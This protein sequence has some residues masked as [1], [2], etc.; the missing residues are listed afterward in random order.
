MEKETA[1]GVNLA[2]LSAVIKNWNSLND[3]TRAEIVRLILENL[4]R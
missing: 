2:E 4:T 1:E 3:E